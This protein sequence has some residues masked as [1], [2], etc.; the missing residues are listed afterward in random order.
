MVQEKDTH[1]LANLQSD[2]G[3]WLT[4]VLLSS[5]YEE[6]ENRKQVR[7][8]ETLPHDVQSWGKIPSRVL[9][10]Q[11]I[12]HELA[13]QI[14]ESKV[15]PSKDTMEVF[16]VTF[17]NFIASLQKLQHGQLLAGLGIDEL[18]GLQTEDRMIVDLER[19]LERRSR[20]GQPFCFVVSRID[21]QKNR[22][23]VE[24]IILAAQAIQ[25]TIR[26]FDDAYITAEGEIIASLKHSDNNGGLKF[27]DRLKFVLNANENIQFTL[28]SIVAEPMPGD[29]IP[30]LISQVV[31]EL[32][33]LDAGEGG[34]AEQ[35]QE[36]SPL[37]QYL[38][39]LKETP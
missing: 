22:E 31:K 32:K 36:V 11:L 6:F 5:L 2:Y 21:D 27:I 16:L 34:K 15:K 8:P 1:F 33:N 7:F 20:R 26:S 39:S 18:T 3:A 23:K 17:E 29:S 10:S 38:K 4:Q 37:A 13:S 24:N 14:L 28:S 25:K 12:L 9:D 30:D 35:Y 19:E